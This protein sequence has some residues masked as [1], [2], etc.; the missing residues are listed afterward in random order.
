MIDMCLRLT[1]PFVGLVTTVK[2]LA[3]VAALASDLDPVS[4]GGK[5]VYSGHIVCAECAM[6]RR[7]GANWGILGR[8]SA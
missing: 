2:G 3:G 1:G 7:K 4:T 8:I 5:L 6:S